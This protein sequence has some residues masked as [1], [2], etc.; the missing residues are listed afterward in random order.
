MTTWHCASLS[1]TLNFSEPQAPYF[2]TLV[3]GND[4][5]GS[6]DRNWADWTIYA[7]N[8]ASDAE[9]TRDAEGWTVIAQEAGIGQDRL[10]GRSCTRGPLW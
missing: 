2:Y 1:K 7:A 5:E 10:R 4:T 3:T 6:P 8:F 9:A